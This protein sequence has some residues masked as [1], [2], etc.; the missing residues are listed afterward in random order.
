MQRMHALLL[1]RDGG[2]PGLRSEES[3][4]AALARPHNLYEY[5]QADLFH[6][7]AAYLFA[8]TKTHHPFID[9]NKRI[10]FAVA[11]VFLA[12]NGWNLDVTE[13]D[14][15]QAV[16]RVASGEMDEEALATWIQAGCVERSETA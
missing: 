8:L 7:A 13:R 15:E 11:L 6:L 14:A 9:G 2:A 12:R 1:E 3:L 16:L 10:G 5:A 4:K